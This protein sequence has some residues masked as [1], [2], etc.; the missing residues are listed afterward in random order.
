[1]IYT[2][3]LGSENNKWFFPIAD[4]GTKQGLNDSGLETFLDKPL[5]SLVRETIQ[6]S[7]D[8]KY[9]EVN[10]PVCVKFN[11]FDIPIKD[12][13]GFDSLKD[14]YI[15]KAKDSWEKESQEYKHLQMSG[16]H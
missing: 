1:M 7:L 8:A 9:P 5:D 11:F 14:E 4:Y 16:S 12:F 13:P 15:T 2:S 3:M 6:N 10:K